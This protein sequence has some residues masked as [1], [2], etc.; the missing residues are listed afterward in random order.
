MYGHPCAVVA[1][2]RALAPTPGA[3]WRWYQG[4]A[5]QG[6]LQVAVTSTTATNSQ[7]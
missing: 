3:F 6:V 5:V 1:H 7:K 4:R 2:A